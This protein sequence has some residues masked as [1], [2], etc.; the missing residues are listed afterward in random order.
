MEVKGLL[1]TTFDGVRVTIKERQ[2]T[3]IVLLVLTIYVVGLIIF[4]G[5]YKKSFDKTIKMPKEE[6]INMDILL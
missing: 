4:C 1:F 3:A 2:Q 6:I 5:L